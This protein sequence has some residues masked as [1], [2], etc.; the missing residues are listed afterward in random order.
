MESSYQ[1]FAKN[2]LVIGVTQVLVVLSGII[3]LPLIT[4]TLGA[5]DYGIWAQ[6][7]VTLTLVVSFARLGLFYTDVG[8]SPLHDTKKG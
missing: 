7:Q 1:K 5:H 3:L 4:K 6:V 8:T 2:V